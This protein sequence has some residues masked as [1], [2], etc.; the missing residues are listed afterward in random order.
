MGISQG[1]SGTE[2][3]DGAEVQVFALPYRRRDPM[4]VE[5]TRT[6]KSVYN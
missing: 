5:N 3:R 2:Q 6:Q 4:S 1:M